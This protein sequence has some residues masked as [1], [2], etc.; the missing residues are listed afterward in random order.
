MTSGTI[1]QL[2]ERQLKALQ[3]TLWAGDSG[4]AQSMG[5]GW[6][7]ERGVHGSGNDCESDRR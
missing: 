4:K 7:A 2:V 6:E 5:I 3:L 1:I